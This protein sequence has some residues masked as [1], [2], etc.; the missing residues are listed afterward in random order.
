MYWTS[1]QIGLIIG[2]FLGPDA[3]IEVQVVYNFYEEGEEAH[4]LFQEG[5]VG[6]RFEGTQL[7][8]VFIHANG[9]IDFG[10]EEGEVYPGVPFLFEGE[11]AFHQC[12]GQDIA[13]LYLVFPVDTEFLLE[14][15]VFEPDKLTAAGSHCLKLLAELA[16]ELL[17]G[18]RQNHRM[19]FEVLVEVSYYE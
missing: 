11:N 1:K 7:E 2:L 3:G 15:R 14:A 5:V 10:V 8:E 13:C 16:E 17:G 6:R 19:G 9:D 4:A 18:V 12:R